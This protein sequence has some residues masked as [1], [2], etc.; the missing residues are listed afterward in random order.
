M[1]L[2]KPKRE[3]FYPDLDCKV[4]LT[5]LIRSWC[6]KVWM[7]EKTGIGP[8][9]W[10][11]WRFLGTFGILKEEYSE[12]KVKRAVETILRTNR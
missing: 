3:F 8:F 2:F 4:V 11:T 7:L 10:W 5:E 1:Q 9:W 12:S 6:G